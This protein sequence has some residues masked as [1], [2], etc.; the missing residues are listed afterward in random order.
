MVIFQKII[1]REDLRRNYASGYPILY[2][3]GDNIKRVGFGGQAAEMRGEPNAVGVATLYAPG[4][5]FTE[6]VASIYS[7]KRVLDTDM[8]PL[9]DHVKGGGIVIWPADGIGTG[10]ARMQICS[11]TTFEYL[12]EKLAALIVISK[13]YQRDIHV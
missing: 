11:P 8:K 1:K 4:I 5:P 9:F 10:L 12:E 2:V 3:F 13:L 7:Q 6:D